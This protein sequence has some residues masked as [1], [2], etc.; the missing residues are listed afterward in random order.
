MYP[1]RF[2]LTFI[3][4]PWSFHSVLFLLLLKNNNKKKTKLFVFNLCVLVSTVQL[5]FL[6]LDNIDNCNVDY[7]M[8]IFFKYSYPVDRIAL[9]NDPLM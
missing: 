5:Y 9:L 8:S 3:F 7:V 2:A 6:Y 4:M 1:D